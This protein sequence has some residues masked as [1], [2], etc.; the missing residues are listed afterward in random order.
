[1][2][3]SQKKHAISPKIIWLRW[4]TESNTLSSKIQMKIKYVIISTHFFRVRW[5]LA[6]ES[7]SVPGTILPYDYNIF[8]IISFVYI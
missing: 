4:S 3:L 8:R 1:M 2:T 6:I 7:L 5:F